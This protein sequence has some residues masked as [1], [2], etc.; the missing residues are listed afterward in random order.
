[1]AL[2]QIMTEGEAC[3]RKVCRPVDCFDASLAALLDDMAETMHDAQG[4]GLAAPQVGLLRRVVVIDVG[5][6]V[7]DLINPVIVEQNGEQTG[8]EGCLSIPGESWIVTRPMHVVCNAQDRTGKAITLEGE[9]L[10]ARAICHELDH[11]DG[12]L[13]TD[14]TD[15]PVE[16]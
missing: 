16:D 1:M 11:L 3:L 9:G 4:V 7:H 13:Y 6:G 10:L 12:I 14:L 15:T 8:P 2:R 5:D